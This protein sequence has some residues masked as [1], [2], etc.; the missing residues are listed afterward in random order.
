MPFYAWYSSAGSDTPPYTPRI[1]RINTESAAFEAHTNADYPF[2]LVA[3]ADGVIV[4]SYN[5]A[6]PYRLNSDLTVAWTFTR[7]ASTL[8]TFDAAPDGEGNTY[9]AYQWNMDGRIYCVDADGVG[10][11]HSTISA[12]SLG[13]G[14]VQPESLCL[15]RDG[16]VLIVLAV[17]TSELDDV[18]LIGVSVAS[19]SVLWTRQLATAAPST[20][21]GLN[22]ATVRLALSGDA[23]YASYLGVTDGYDR[24]RVARVVFGDGW[25]SAPTVAWE[26]E[27]AQDEWAGFLSGMTVTSAGV[28][29]GYSASETGGGDPHI[30]TAFDEDG[31]VLWRFTDAS[32]VDDGAFTDIF[33]LA[34]G[35]YGTG[36][37]VMLGLYSSEFFP[38]EGYGFV[39]LDDT[40]GQV[41]YIDG[42]P[43]EVLVTGQ[44]AAWAAG[45]LPGPEQP[46]VPPASEPLPFETPNPEETTSDPEACPPGETTS[47]AEACPPPMTDPCD[48]GDCAEWD[49]VFV[50]WDAV[51]T[52]WDEC[53]DII[54]G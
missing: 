31:D 18:R 22:F 2:R 44:V 43:K 35:D 23:V 14:Q 51:A 8:V 41:N 45:Q 10:V 13:W 42:W 39:L 34:W 27:P 19:G 28:V 53:G 30:A 47:K 29:V 25:S 52:E 33:S 1:A 16:T 17:N 40:S 4:C 36:G 48:D 26:R 5:T 21:S 37:F 20:F 49:E 9:L 11:L 46:Y 7:P 6:D 54:I 24:P 3:D 38:E 50:Q 32:W 15:S 12:A